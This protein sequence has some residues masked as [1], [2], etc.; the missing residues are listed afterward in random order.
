MVVAMCRV[1]HGVSTAICKTDRKLCHGLGLHSARDVVDLVKIDRIM[2]AEKYH[3][4][5]MLLHHAVPSGV[6][7][8]M[9]SICS[10][11]MSPNTL[12]MQ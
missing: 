7:L 10:M 5:C 4:T 9:A 2:N 11:T 12:P 3:Q 1:R 6:Q 8:A